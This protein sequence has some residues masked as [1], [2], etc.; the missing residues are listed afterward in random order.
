MVCE[1]FMKDFD[2]RGNVIYLNAWAA[3]VD[4]MATEGWKVIECCRKSEY[5]GFWTVVLAR[6][7]RDDP[8]ILN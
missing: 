7:W 8:P 5:P 2:A 1:V 3:E 6:T 4:Q